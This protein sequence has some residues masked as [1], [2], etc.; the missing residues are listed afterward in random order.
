MEL[1]FYLCWTACLFLMIKWRAD[2]N[3]QSIRLWSLKL[4]EPT[5]VCFRVI[6]THCTML[7]KEQG[8]IVRLE[9]WFFIFFFKLN[10]WGT[11]LGYACSQSSLQVRIFDVSERILSFDILV[12]ET[13]IHGTYSLGDTFKTTNN[14]FWNQSL[15][16]GTCLNSVS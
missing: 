4:I 3:I 2:N 13:V 16:F 6:S 5:R 7:P 12:N 10:H 15:T 11:K 9:G 1:N 8:W 14:H